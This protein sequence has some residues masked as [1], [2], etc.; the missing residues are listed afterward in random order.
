M[1]RTIDGLEVAR[2]LRIDL[3]AAEAVEQVYSRCPIT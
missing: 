2:C 1:P 3:Q